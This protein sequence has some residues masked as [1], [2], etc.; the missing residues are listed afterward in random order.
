MTDVWEIWVE[1]TEGSLIIL[2]P[3]PECLED[4]NPLNATLNPTCHLLALLRVH[5]I[6]YVRRIRVNEMYI[7]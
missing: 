7:N 3:D 4:I 1:I 5:S 2:G 6:L